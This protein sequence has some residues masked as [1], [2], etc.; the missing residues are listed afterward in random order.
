MLSLKP[1]HDLNFRISAESWSIMECL[2][3]FNR[4]GDFY[5]PEITHAISSAGK[6]SSTFLRGYC[7]LCDIFTFATS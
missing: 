1:E 6:S 5:I 3:H 7:F 4:Y 2:E